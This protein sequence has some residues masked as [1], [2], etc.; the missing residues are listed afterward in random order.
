MSGWGP[1]SSSTAAPP[2]RRVGSAPVLPVAQ[3]PLSSS[4][5]PEDDAGLLRKL[6]KRRSSGANLMQ[7]SRG[8]HRAAFLCC[9]ATSGHVDGQPAAGLVS[10][11]VTQPLL[12]LLLLLALLHN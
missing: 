6:L 3:G 7:A 1:S 12:L 8:W 10:S 5:P 11:A 2:R 4:Y 9:Y